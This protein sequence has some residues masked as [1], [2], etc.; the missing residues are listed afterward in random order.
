[1]H[2][3]GRGVD[4]SHLSAAIFADTALNRGERFQL[5]VGGQSIDVDRL[6]EAAVN[7]RAA[8]V[9]MAKGDRF[10]EMHP[11]GKANRADRLSKLAVAAGPQVAMLRGERLEAVGDFSRSAEIDLPVAVDVAPAIDA[12]QRVVAI[13]AAIAKRAEQ[14]DLHRL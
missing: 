7:R 14:V 3:V 10:K 13:G 11:F 4:R 6:L 5:R 12:N 2:A 8:V 1:M 9:A